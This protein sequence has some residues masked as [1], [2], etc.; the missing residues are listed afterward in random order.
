MPKRFA[1]HSSTP[2]HKGAQYLIESRSEHALLAG[3]QGRS[4]H[5]MAEAFNWWSIMA[6]GWVLSISGS[7][8]EIPFL[9]LP[10][11]D[12]LFRHFL[13]AETPDSIHSNLINLCEFLQVLTSSLQL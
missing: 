5:L 13:F 1:L 10:F 2:E 11:S 4:L 12:F 9:V 6:W 7:R 8:S 3:L